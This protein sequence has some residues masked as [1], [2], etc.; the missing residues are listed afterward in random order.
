MSTK[1]YFSGFVGNIGDF[2]VSA[3]SSFGLIKKVLQFLGGLM[4]LHV[5]ISEFLIVILKY[6]I[7]SPCTFKDLDMSSQI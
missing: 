1:T 4:F 3:P 5:Y 6:A 7:F 2:A